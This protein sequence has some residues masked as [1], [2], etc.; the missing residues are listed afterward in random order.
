MDTN[1][2]GMD[3]HNSKG[4]VMVDMDNKGQPV[5]HEVGLP[6]TWICQDFAV[7]RRRVKHKSAWVD[8][9]LAVFVYNKTGKT[10]EMI[11]N[12]LMHQ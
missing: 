5:F 2:D 12:C 1:I 10:R 3:V 11:G 8:H 4:I 9:G 6:V 7:L